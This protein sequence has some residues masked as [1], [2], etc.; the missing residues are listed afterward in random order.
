M[1]AHYP[2][3]LPVTDKGEISA[4]GIHIHA[5]RLPDIGAGVPKLT[6]QLPPLPGS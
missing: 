5:G 2:K 1:L 4:K 6:E 3:L